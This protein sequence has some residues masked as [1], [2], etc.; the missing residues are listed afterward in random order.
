METLIRLQNLF[1]NVLLGVS[2]CPTPLM[3]WDLKILSIPMQILKAK[4]LPFHH[5]S[6]LPGNSLGKQ[7]LNKQQRLGLPSVFDEIKPFLSKYEVVNV[8]S[9]SKMEWSGFIN[10]KI[11]YENRLQILEAS[12]GYKKL[13]SLS[14]SCEDYEVKSYFYNLNLAQSCVKFRQRS[15]TMTHC[16]MHYLSQYLKTAFVCPSCTEGNSN[17]YQKP[18][19]FDQLS[20]WTVCSKY[21]KMRL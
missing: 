6:T 16:R 13:D 21:A 1:L 4:L 12:K 9:V 15:L 7:V 10:K 14:L 5:V 18:M 11:D 19:F 2:N 20:H 8:N 3:L 17:D